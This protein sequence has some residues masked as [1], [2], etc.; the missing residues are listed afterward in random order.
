MPTEQELVRDVDGVTLAHR[1]LVE[2]IDGWQ[3][4][5][6]EPTAPSRLPDWTVGHVL[7]HLARN[8]DSFVR[9]IEGAAAGEVLDQYDDGVVSRGRDIAAGAGRSAVAL[10]DDVRASTAR[11]D[12]AFAATDWQGAGRVTTGSVGP[13]VDLPA[14][15]RREV[16]VHHVDLGLGYEP[17]DWP[18]DFV[19]V[20]LRRQEMTAKSRLPMGLT[21]WPEPVL[22]L[23]PAER[24]AWLFGRIHR[25]GLPELGPWA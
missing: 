23:P 24:L 17:G 21:T 12:Q 14:R 9:M 25:P 7:T 18:A 16:E 6:A 10:A 20:E 15:R 3:A 2:R 4:G 11:L 8:A 5:G 1:R 13:L 22:A 19:R